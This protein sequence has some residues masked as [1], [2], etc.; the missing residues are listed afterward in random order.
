[1]IQFLRNVN[2]FSLKL[3]VVFGLVASMLLLGCEKEIPEKSIDSDILVSAKYKN[4]KVCIEAETEKKFQCINYTIKNSTLREE[5][6]IAIDF[7]DVSI[8]G[9]CLIAFGPAKAEIDL[10]E[11]ELG[12]YVLKFVLDG[13]YTDAKLKV[14]SQVTLELIKAGNVKLK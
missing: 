6:T 7:M 2:I 9:I 5:K 1:M 12:D 3:L 10:D 13:I 14:D 11:L 4:G 8:L